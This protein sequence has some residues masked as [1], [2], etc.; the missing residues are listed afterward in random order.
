MLLLPPQLLLFSYCL[1]QYLLSLNVWVHVIQNEQL[2]WVWSG[3]LYLTNLLIIVFR[4][5]EGRILTVNLYR[6]SQHGPELGFWCLWLILTN[7]MTLWTLSLKAWAE[8]I[9]VI[10]WPSMVFTYIDRDQFQIACSSLFWTPS[11]QELHEYNLMQ[12][13]SYS[14]CFDI[15]HSEGQANSFFFFLLLEFLEPD[16]PETSCIFLVF[17]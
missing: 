9:K 12:Q 6:Y 7:M 5:L 4:Q 3:T 1:R 13:K 14:V 10:E 17:E 8:A 2:S 15:G 11:K 16:I